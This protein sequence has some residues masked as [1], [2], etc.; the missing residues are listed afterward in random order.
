M[1][2]EKL[3]RLPSWDL[4]AL[5]C[6]AD[7]P[8]IAE[9]LRDAH[10]RADEFQ[11]AWRG[12]ITDAS[13]PEDILRALQEYEAILQ[14]AVKPYL[15]ADLLHATDV[16]NPNHGALAQ[17]TQVALTDIGNKLLF[18]GLE[19]IGLSDET[20]RRLVDGDALKNYAHY[21]EK[22]LRTKPHRLIEREEQMMNDFSL[23]GASA[24]TRL[25][26]EELSRKKFRVVIDSETHEWPE[27]KV[28]NLLHDADREKR[29][30]GADAI[31]RELEKDLWRLTYIFN[32]LAQD[33][34]ISDR[35]QKY[36]TPEASRHL[37]NETTQEMVDTMSAAVS[38]G[39][40]VV[41]DYYSLKR[42]VLGLSELYDYDRYAPVLAS[43]K[44]Y[45]FDEA[46]E[47]V[48]SA[49]GKFSPVMR[50]KGSEFF[51]KRWIDA[52][53]RHG[54]RGGAFC[55][56]MT[57]DTHPVVFLNYLGATKHVL[58]LAHELGHGVHASLMRKHTLLNFDTPLTIAETASVFGEML[59]FDSLRKTL[60]GKERVALYMGKI[61]EIFAT[62]FRQH[63]MYKFEQDFHTARRSEDE[64]KSERIGELWM[65]HQKAMFGD[66]VTMRDDYSLW[67]SY[68][69]HFLH[70]PFY[71]Y[72]YTFGELL[73]LSLYDTY[74]KTDDKA[75]FADTYIAM[76]ETGGTKSPQELVDPFGV[77][78]SSKEFWQGGIRVV[79]EMVEEAR[80]LN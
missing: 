37:A 46:R 3:G 17:K 35:Y 40:G 29:K 4:S 57:P 14:E 28:L 56:Y 21:L 50:E 79:R 58:T 26:D 13:L 52:E 44:I 53:A 10:Q 39:I 43:E 80:K 38:E 45:S 68:I 64:L 59:V 62:V 22:L 31:T 48:L 16:E 65:S 71:V 8:R 69:P 25:F 75:A 32:T 54:K 36:A 77:D 41:A 6:G 18:L 30:A 61:E 34:H 27:E 7:D 63:A 12:K 2:H 24:F 19:L 1:E 72:A 51:E 70:T 67:W 74:L 5:F 9:T 20:L 76:L 15:Y 78:L 11:Q 47:I 60:E 49:Y 55:S 42:E 33:K 23:T 73:T 66:S